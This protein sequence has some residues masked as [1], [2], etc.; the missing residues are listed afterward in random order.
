MISLSLLSIFSDCFGFVLKGCGM[1][2]ADE[3]TLMNTLQ[4]VPV[5]RGKVKPPV[6]RPSARLAFLQQMEAHEL[7]AIQ[8]V[9]TPVNISLDAGTQHCK[10]AI[11]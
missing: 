3:L 9:D 1:S 7:S 6:S 2:S 4:Q 10:K 11:T 5:N 8:E